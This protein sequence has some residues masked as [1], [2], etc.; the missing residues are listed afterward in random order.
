MPCSWCV[1]RS[2]VATRGLRTWFLLVFCSLVNGSWWFQW[3]LKVQSGWHHWTPSS[4]QV[5]NLVQN[6][7]VR[8]CRGRS[9]DVDCHSGPS[10]GFTSTDFVCALLIEFQLIKCTGGRLLSVIVFAKL[11]TFYISPMFYNT[12][13][14]SLLVLWFLVQNWCEPTKI[15][16][17]KQG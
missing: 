17:Q 1:N 4:V 3:F 11:P 14:K 9:L 7:S 8:T 5:Q 16:N 12:R 2:F 15:R 13:R 6:L 10:P